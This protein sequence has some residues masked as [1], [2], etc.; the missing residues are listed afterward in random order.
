MLSPFYPNNFQ[1]FSKRLKEAGVRVLGIGQ[2]PYGQLGESLQNDLTE[3][4]RVDDL[5]DFDQVSRAVAFF[6]FK[7]GKIDRIESHNEHWLG[8]EASLRNEFN[9]YGPKPKDLVKVKFK[10]E[11]KKLFKKA[12]VPVAPGLIIN[13]VKE[14][15]QA[16]KKFKLPVIAKP[17][18]GV[19]TAKTFQV[20]NQDDIEWFKEKWDRS[21][22][23]FVE[24]FV[25][26]GKLCTY[27]GLIDGQ[28]NIVFEASF[29]Y[30]EP[31]LESLIKQSD[32][33]YYMQ[34]EIPPELKRHGQ[35]IVKEFGMRERFFHIE[36]FQLPNGSFQTLEYNNRPAGGWTLDTY[37][38]SYSVDLYKEYANVVTGKE[39]GLENYTK[40]FG[41]N[42]TQRNTYHYKHYHDEIAE[43][44][45]DRL[46]MSEPIPQ[47][48]ATLQGDYLYTIVTQDKDEIHEIE[49]FIT[50][51]YD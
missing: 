10:S 50:E 28:G 23:Y 20:K 13:S 16:V 40:Q 42:V 46:R 2:E 26:E 11:M 27:D 43:K 1:L 14:F 9:V 7:Y 32:L 30:K 18:S 29:F 12:K 19:G 24:P 44:Y 38:H 17:D 35:A 3:Y 37:N 8:L 36:F 41:V 49:K 34:K 47:A 15:D 51:K 21:V 31:T 25:S 4:Y 39:V 6:Y 33:A 48:F 5:E 22:P 45:Q